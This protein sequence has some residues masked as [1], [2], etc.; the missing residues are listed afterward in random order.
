MWVE[1]QLVIAAVRRAAV[2]A[3]PREDVDDAVLDLLRDAEQVHV[4][5][6]ARRALDLDLVAVVLVEALQALDEQEVDRQ[7]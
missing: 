4:L 5:A 1:V 3:V 7:P 2:L 6:R